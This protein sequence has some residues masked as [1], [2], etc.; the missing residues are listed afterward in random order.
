MSCYQTLQTRCLAIN[1]LKCIYTPIS[2]NS[3]EGVQVGE[4]QGALNFATVR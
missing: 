3:S 1:T 4:L 2:A